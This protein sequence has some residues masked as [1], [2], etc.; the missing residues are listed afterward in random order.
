MTNEVVQGELGWWS[1][2]ARRDWLRLKFWAKIVGG[3][4][5]KRRL[6]ARVYEQSRTRY[7]AG[8]TGSRWCRH[9]HELLTQLGM[10]KAWM[11]DAL[12][13]DDD[14]D[15][16]A[17]G[18]GNGNG[19]GE[20]EKQAPATPEEKL[21]KWHNT[22][23]DKLHKR[24]EQDWL[25][26]MT[27]KPKT[28]TY[29]TLK[30]KLT[31]QKA[32]LSYP[33]REARRVMTRLRGGTNELRI[34]TGRHKI[35]SRDK[36]LPLLERT[37]LLCPSDD[38]KKRDVEDETH[39]VL[40]C[41]LYEDLREKTIWSVVRKSDAMMKKMKT[42]FE[43]DTLEEARKHAGGRRFLLAGLLGGDEMYES[44]LAPDLTFAALRFCKSAMT[45]RNGIVLHHLDQKT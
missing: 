28:R 37:C 6:V 25:H 31:F 34:E 7:E 45:R 27:T 40:D 17:I 29:R 2:K 1:L 15:D 21:N 33:D 8:M 43:C 14:D 12:E 10:A 41:E 4:S 42:E 38:E 23:R 24:E 30:H 13:L 39:F 22:L 44:S 20:K 16:A 36:P 3:M 19:K 35:T 9:T 18:N 26:R 32:Y 11:N 5:R